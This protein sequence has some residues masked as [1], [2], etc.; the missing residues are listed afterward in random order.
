MK[1]RKGSA[2][3]LALII[4]L[5]AVIVLAGIMPMMNQ[6]MRATTSDHDVLQAQYA[7]EAGLKHAYLCLLSANKVDSAVFY[8]TLDM[9]HADNKTPQYYISI[10]PQNSSTAITAGTTLSAGT[11]T[12]TS[13]G[14]YNGITKA[15]SEYVTLS[16]GG[17]GPD[18]IWSP[19]TA[20]DYANTGKYAALADGNLTAWGGNTVTNNTYG[21][22]YELASTK[23]LRPEVQVPATGQVQDVYLK[24]LSPT[25]FST[26]NPRLSAYTRA[27]MDATMNP[28]IQYSSSWDNLWSNSAITFP[29]GYNMYTTTTNVVVN[30]PLTL[31]DGDRVVI[32]STKDIEINRPVSG[33]FVFIA[34]GD[35]QLNAACSGHI[36]F[37]SKKNMRIYRSVTGYGLFMSLSDLTVTQ[38]TYNKAFMFGDNGV[39]LSGANI[40]GA[41]YS[42]STM[43]LN[44]DTSVTY[45]ASAIPKN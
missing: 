37:Y 2:T 19:P 35:I 18:V 38:G 5:F 11:Y 16:A 24:L 30:T 36:E 23:K 21:S 44:G 4:V 34:H 32:Y 27:T 22:S 41:V 7:A 14:S 33:H 43:V 20:A 28:D 40:T 25:F 1:Q 15:V 31:A 13:T 17:T 3:A 6:E 9:N 10:T 12:V 29:S 8:Q 26:S 45:D 42:N 39:T